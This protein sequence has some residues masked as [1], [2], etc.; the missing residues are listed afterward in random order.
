MVD[1]LG[2]PLL[3]W[4]RIPCLV[5]NPLMQI[6]EHFRCVLLFV[7]DQFVFDFEYSTLGFGSDLGG[8]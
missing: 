1:V 3:K 7:A 5:I 2:N 8:N 6:I 4:R